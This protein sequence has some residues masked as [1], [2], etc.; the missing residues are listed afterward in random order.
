MRRLLRYG[1]Y[2]GLSILVLIAISTLYAISLEAALFYGFLPE[3]SK[4]AFAGAII[5][6]CIGI[7]RI[8]L[9]RSY[10]A[11][12]I[13]TSEDEK[14][15]EIKIESIEI[16][17]KGK[18]ANIDKEIERIRT[19]ELVTTPTPGLP[20]TSNLYYK[21]SRERVRRTKWA[22]ALCG[23][24]LI[25][26]VLFLLPSLAFL[27]KKDGKA[28]FEKGEKLYK[29]G[30]W[31]DALMYF[32]KA[33]EMNPKFAS[34][35]NRRGTI[36]YLYRENHDKAIQDFTKAIEID[37]K[38]ASAYVWRGGCY[39]EKGDY[40]KAIKDYATALRV[41]NDKW[42]IERAS[43]GLRNVYWQ[44]GKSTPKV[45]IPT[46]IP[47]APS[48]EAKIDPSKLG[49]DINM[50]LRNAG[51]R[52]VTAEVSGDLEVTLRGSVSS[53]E[54]KNRIFR[55]VRGVKGVKEIKDVIFVIE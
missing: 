22:I 10:E 43:R 42:I 14:T 32:N 7:Y 30:L 52:G 39:S 55:I 40:N 29:S 33:I 46:P 26:V 16:K 53:I 41:S 9:R 23:I 5:G 47:E 31:D 20:I 36:Y 45:P 24:S 51:L 38:Y 6:A 25:A 11:E 50:A 48:P 12:R 19:G 18:I 3:V 21:D 8:I 2:A 13:D 1:G 34:A 37:P 35:Y 49:G 17:T 15:L 27:L 28:C 54:E 44:L 4:G